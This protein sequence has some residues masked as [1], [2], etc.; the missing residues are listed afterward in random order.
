MGRVSWDDTDEA[1]GACQ[2]EALKNV[3]SYVH[4]GARRH[5]KAGIR[6]GIA[7]YTLAATTLESFADP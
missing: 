1:G 6:G 2:Y 3:L 4:V 5:D 7:G